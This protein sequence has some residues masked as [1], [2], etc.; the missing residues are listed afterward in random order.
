[1]KQTRIKICG[2]TTP[3][4]AQVAVRAGADYLGLVFAPR[5]PRVLIR[6]RA[7]EILD[8]LPKS[9]M[10]IPLF[11][12]ADP[13][14]PVFRELCVRC[15]CVQLHGEES[16]AM[17]DTL[18]E[19]MTIIRGFKFSPSET[20]RWD[21]CKGVTHLLIDGSSGGGGNSFDYDALIAMKDEITK[22]IFLAGGLTPKNVEQAIRAVRPFAV[23]V[24]SGVEDPP[25]SGLKS[26][27]LIWSFCDAVRKADQEAN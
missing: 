13:D 4:M 10:G 6:D 19:R 7:V 23:D 16:E 15:G 22:P 14:D 25:G 1:M 2:I 17:I 3:E 18:P 27:E 24:S 20:K 12:N 21:N 26:P 11:Q 8:G 9:V 5:S